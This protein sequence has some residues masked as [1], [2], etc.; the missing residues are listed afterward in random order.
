MNYLLKTIS[1]WVATN[2]DEAQF[3]I[4]ELEIDIIFIPIFIEKI[5]ISMAKISVVY[6]KTV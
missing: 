1:Y 2:L 4:Q 3:K 5:Y 6:G